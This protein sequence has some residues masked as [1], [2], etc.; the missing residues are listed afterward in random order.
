VDHA[1][2]V[3]MVE[4][5]G[6]L[7]DDLGGLAEIEAP[8]GLRLRQRGALDAGADD[9]R[10]GLGVPHL[11]DRHD[12]GVAQPGRVP[13]LMDEPVHVGRRR[14]PVQ[15]RHLHGH[16]AVQ[17]DVPGAVHG[18]ERALADHLEQ[19]E[20]AQAG[21]PGRR[22]RFAGTRQRRRDVQPEAAAA[23]GTGDRLLSRARFGGHGLLAMRTVRPGR[24]PALGQVRAAEALRQV[25]PVLGKPAD[26]VG[27][28]EPGFAAAAQL[29]LRLDQPQRPRPVAGEL[30]IALEIGF[31]RDRLAGFPAALQV[32]VYQLEH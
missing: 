32:R 2:A 16:D 19:L 8:A 4:G 27:R 10:H 7:R 24:Q 3:G 6:D 15:A 30:R 18:P 23:R 9:V 22:T 13:R 25:V 12:T 17:L 21:R 20:L 31:D 28:A 26:V 11:V 29:V 5:V 1:L 14:R